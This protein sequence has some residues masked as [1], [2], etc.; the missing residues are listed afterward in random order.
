MHDGPETVR[1]RVQS[2]PPALRRVGPGR[3]RG[4]GSEECR[5]V[6]VLLVARLRFWPP[7]DVT[8]GDVTER[9]NSAGGVLP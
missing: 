9:K 8:D 2:S 5:S 1:A 7:A 6:E 3:G 4:A